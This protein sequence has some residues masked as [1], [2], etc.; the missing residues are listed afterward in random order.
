LSISAKLRKELDQH[1]SNFVTSFIASSSWQKDSLANDI[2]KGL[3]ERY[4]LTYYPYRIEALDI[5]HLSGAWAS[6]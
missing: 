3:Q 2:L 5:S 6:G 4:G 1:F